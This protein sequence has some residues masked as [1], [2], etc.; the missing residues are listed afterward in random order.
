MQGALHWLRMYF[1]GASLCCHVA[2]SLRSLARADLTSLS[3]CAS[4]SFSL[5][6]SLLTP[7]FPSPWPL[8]FWGPGR[9]G[10]STAKNGQDGGQA[11]RRAYRHTVPCFLGRCSQGCRGPRAP[12]VG[13]R[14]LVGFQG[15]FGA[16]ADRLTAHARSAAVPTPVNRAATRRRS[17]QT[18][19]PGR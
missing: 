5:A 17:C 9:T 13:R 12:L 8:P 2:P 10:G 11:G 18:R 15:C 14:R 3:L 1:H 7:V 4:F 6:P 19:Q 16:P